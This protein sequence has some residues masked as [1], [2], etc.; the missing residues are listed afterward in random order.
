MPQSWADGVLEID[1][2]KPKPESARTFVEARSKRTFVGPMP[3]YIGRNPEPRVLLGLN[4]KGDCY[5]VV[6]DPNGL[7]ELIEPMM[8]LNFM[9]KL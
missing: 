7:E 8:L 2:S 4:V 9:R 1:R 3:C 5:E 6:Y